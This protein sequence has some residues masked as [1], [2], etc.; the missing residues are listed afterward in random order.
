MTRYV[1]TVLLFSMAYQALATFPVTIRC[2]KIIS[3][4]TQSEIVWDW[5]EA[6]GYGPEPEL[7]SGETFVV[8]TV[9]LQKGR[10]ICL[11]MAEGRNAFDPAFAEKIYS[12]PD[13]I[14][15]VYKVQERENWDFEFQ[16]SGRIDPIKLPP[17]AN[18]PPAAAAPAPAPEQTENQEEPA[19]AA[20]P[21]QGDDALPDDF[22]TTE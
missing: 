6:D 7:Q 22:Q 11:G 5:K 16:L 14:G 18:P 2:G 17:T 13:K 1:L 8:I 9:V 3:F 12:G 19:P 10:S 20:D 4:K 15:L 21:A